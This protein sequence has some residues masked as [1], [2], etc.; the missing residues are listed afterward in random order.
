MR[1]AFFET[2]TAIADRNPRVMLLSADLGYKLFDAFAARFPGRFL[3]M[4]VSEANM[5]SVA[6]GLALEGWRPI[7]YSIVPFATARCLEQ[8]RDDV[9]AMDMPVVVTGVGG[10]LAYGVNGP[11]HHGVDD[12]ALMRALPGMTV[13]CPCD[14]RQVTQAITALVER[15]G[16]AYLRLERQ[17]EPV[18]AETGHAPLVIGQPSLFRRGRGLALIACGSVT[19]EA[20]KAAEALTSDGFDPLVLSLHTLKPVM[21]LDALLRQHGVDAVATIEEHG[22]AGGL[23]DAVSAHLAAAGMGLAM[24]QIGL[25]DRFL[26]V[27]GSQ[28]SMCEEHGL[29]AD[30]IRQRIL[31][32]LSLHESRSVGP[33]RT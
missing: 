12:L 6:A 21:G 25:P 5:V 23:F 26:D 8:I 31:A 16:P 20:M 28:D 2:V 3:N 30:A 33:D 27:C 7:V 18:L 32:G 10:G 9:C 17:G 22:P 15:G 29:R 11:T 4:G 14:P 1:N 19:R 24:C 13:V